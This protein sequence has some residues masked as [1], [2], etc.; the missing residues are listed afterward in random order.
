MWGRP[1]PMIWAR[2]EAAS[3]QAAATRPPTRQQPPARLI[4]DRA[5][6]ICVTKAVY[7]LDGSIF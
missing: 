5:G 4:T 1:Q 7:D 3:M 2:A 6:P